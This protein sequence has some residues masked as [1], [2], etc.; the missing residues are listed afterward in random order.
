MLRDRPS[1]RVLAP[2][3]LVAA[4]LA[5]A[6]SLKTLAVRSMADTL[7]AS[8]DTFASDADPELVRDAI[9]FALKTY[10][11]LLESVPRHEGLLVATCSGFTQYAYAFVQADAD[12]LGAEAFDRASELRDRALKLYLRG[13]DYCLRALELRHVGSTKALMLT[14]ATALRDARAE[15]VGLLYWTGASWGAAIAIGLDRPELVA[16]L[17]A[18]R[19]LMARALEL[20]EDYA[21]GALHEAMISLESVPEIMGGSPDRARRHFERAVALSKGRSAGPYVTLA[22]SV[23]VPAQDRAEFTRLLEQA[24][25]IDPDRHPPTRL[26]NL[27]MQRRARHLLAHAD[28][29]FGDRASLAARGPG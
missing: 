29:L 17:P 20:D 13:R 28:D 19:R 22:A 10:E 27:I 18:V 7:S 14:P 8:G 26:A 21:D 3:L 25:A 4:G 2:A 24:L 5:A 23:S 1:P 12:L 11:T 15:E 6:C 16:D 9:P